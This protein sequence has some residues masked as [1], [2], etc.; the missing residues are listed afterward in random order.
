MQRV[1]ARLLAWN[2]DGARA[3]AM[4]RLQG[5]LDTVCGKLPAADAQRAVCEGL[6]VAAAGNGNL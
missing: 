4:Q 3:A 1:G 6:F 2:K 5:K